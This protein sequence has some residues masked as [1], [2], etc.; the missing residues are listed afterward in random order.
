M[1]ERLLKYAGAATLCLLA[2]TAVSSVIFPVYAVPQRLVLYASLIAAAAFIFTFSSKFLRDKDKLETP[3]DGYLFALLV[4]TAAA[5]VFSVNRVQSL[6]MTALLVI[7]L[8]LFY[9]SYD[10]SKKY[11]KELLSS[12]LLASVI[13]CF[14]GFYQFLAGFRETASALNP[15]HPLYS[16]YM[17]RLESGR[18][19]SFFVY[20]NSFASFLIM[21]I[22]ASAGIA[23]SDRRYR[24]PAAAALL[25]LLAALFL[26][27]SMGA[28]LSIF[29]AV[30][31]SVSITTDEPLKPFRQAL[32]LVSAAIAAFAVAAFFLRGPDTFL[33]GF[34]EK[35]KSFI[36]MAELIKDRFLLGYGPGT[37]EQVYNAGR[38]DKLSYLK[39]A[40]NAPL[41]SALE[42][43][44]V[45]LSIFM[46]MFLKAVRAVSRNYLFLKSTRTK[47]LV[48]SLL[49]GLTAFL[50]HNLGDFG[51]F[52]FENALVFT[53]LSGVL[54]SNT[55]SGTIEVR[56]FK[57]SYLLGINPGL[58]RDM[59][60][61]LAASAVA[62]SAITGGRHPYAL[63]AVY[64]LITAGF[65]IWWVS[66]EDIRRTALDIPL[67]F[68]AA[69]SAVS[70]LYTPDLN[71]GFYS[72]KLVFAAIILYFLSS[73]F[74]RRSY[75]RIVLSNVIIISGGTAALVAVIQ[76]IYTYVTGKSAGSWAFFPNP[77][78]FAGYL[79]IP[80]ALVL[81]RILLE[82]KIDL[83][84]VKTG[85]VILFVATAA[86]SGSKGGM[87]TMIITTS[88]IWLYYSSNKQNVKD[89]SSR[90]LFKLWMLR[91]IIALLLLLSFTGIAPSGKKMLGVGSDPFYF[92]RIEIYRAS[93][94]MA[95]DSFLTGRGIGGYEAS[96]PRYNFPLENST[97]RYGVYA[98]FAHNEY[99]QV[100]CELGIAGLLALLALLYRLLRRLPS[101]LG[102]KKLWSAGAGA[103][104]AVASAA[105]H[106]LFDFNMHLPVTLFTCAVLASFITREEDL[107]STVPKSAMMFTRVYY[108]PALLLTTLMALTVVRPALSKFYYDDFKK[109]SGMLSITNAA[110][111][112]PVRSSLALDAYR[113]GALYKDQSGL[114]YLSNALY[115]DRF[116]STVLLNAAR[117]QA[118][119]NNRAGA[120]E[121]YNQAKKSDPYRALIYS[122]EAGF[123]LERGGNSLS[124]R[125]L[126]EHAVYL[127]PN[128]IPARINLSSLYMQNKEYKAALEQL[129]EAEFSMNS[130]MPLTPYEENLMKLPSRGLLYNN[131]ALVLKALKHDSEACDYS[132]KAVIEGMPKPPIAGCK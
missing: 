52:T 59:V 57:L 100:F 47:I 129:D 24:I 115:F 73:Q 112:E 105:F 104:F 110:D 93:L 97:S 61:F 35:I 78:L 1:R 65:G 51:I 80:Y 91:A 132:R 94:K 86:I 10:V 37:F 113:T 131:K 30:V 42:T 102:H 48:I 56:K 90:M 98:N 50:I 49:T 55:V 96:F 69:F 71:A 81:C 34:G 12:V 29:A 126:L 15:S 38:P 130:F 8:L 43:G 40:H 20:P 76:F 67:L 122:E 117:L 58:R 44:I 11:G 53:I 124:A 27:K 62:L 70:L 54:M 32:L 88:L 79:S 111:S 85:L 95:F 116:N 63:S 84:A 33:M 13:A 99:L 75:Y 45:G 17:Q 4:W 89:N 92:N 68:T 83:L 120:L 119:Y 121:Y 128:F 106:A 3:V 107:I 101:H 109:T 82:K 77:N 36:R 6:N 87:L 46:F 127:E 72:F 26:T 18:I 31:I 16:A 41:Q 23:L 114:K 7:L 28:F 14:Y 74:L 25:M 103:Y 9:A 19:F 39:F 125:N 64:L 66:K 108:F 118:S 123:Q 5:S 21:L 60:F 22:P 2:V